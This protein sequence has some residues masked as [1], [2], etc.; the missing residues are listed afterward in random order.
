MIKLSD[1]RGER[2]Y[3]EDGDIARFWWDVRQAIRDVRLYRRWLRQCGI[4]N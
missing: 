3:T 4:I 2:R 1:L